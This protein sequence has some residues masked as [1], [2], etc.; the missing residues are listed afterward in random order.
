MK[1]IIATTILSLSTSALF[2]ILTVPNFSF[3]E[4]TGQYT[5]PTSWKEDQPRALSGAGFAHSGYDSNTSG[6]LPFDG[7]QYGRVSIIGD[8][9]PG[10]S[11][12]ASI[13]TQAGLIGTFEADTIYALTFQVARNDY[14][15]ANQRFLYSGFRADGQDVAVITDDVRSFAQIEDQWTTVT[16]NFD[17]S[18]SPDAVGKDISIFLG[19]EHRDNYNKS[20]FFDNVTLAAVPEPSTYAMLFGALAVGFT[21]W[22]RHKNKQ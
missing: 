8:D 15:T 13:S 9:D 6:L 12:S 7:S 11:F 21:L 22:R 20:V 19:W 2:A 18:L 3:E 14:Y 17:T 10:T 1:K 4:G 5:P 16:L